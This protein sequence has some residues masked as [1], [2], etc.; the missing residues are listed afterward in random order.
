[1]QVHAS[2]VLHDH[3]TRV[4]SIVIASRSPAATSPFPTIIIHYV[5]V[6][7]AFTPRYLG[8]AVSADG[9]GAALFAVACLNLFLLPGALGRCDPAHVL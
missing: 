7:L 5:A 4:P 3:S 8:Q 2:Y 9:G 6:L 1:M